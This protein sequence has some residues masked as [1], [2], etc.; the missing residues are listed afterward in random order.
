MEKTPIKLFELEPSVT[1]TRRFCSQL[2]MN[3]GVASFIFTDGQMK[4]Y[5]YGDKG[6][7]FYDFNDPYEIVRDAKDMVVQQL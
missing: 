6:F 2:E 4:E 1:G 5:Q 3:K 7:G